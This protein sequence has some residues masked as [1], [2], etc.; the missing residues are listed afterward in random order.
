MMSS[1]GT[2]CPWLCMFGA[3]NSDCWNLN[4]E[5]CWWRTFNNGD[6][7]DEE[8]VEEDDADD[9]SYDIDDD[10]NEMMMEWCRSF[11]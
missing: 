4:W 10:E 2:K 3:E 9:D 6:G 7:D 8:V 11:E 5:L 1:D